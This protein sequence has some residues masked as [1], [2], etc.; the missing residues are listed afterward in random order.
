MLFYSIASA[1]LPSFSSSTSL[2]SKNSWSVLCTLDPRLKS[3]RFRFPVWAGG[4]RDDGVTGQAGH[5]AMVF[6]DCQ[7]GDNGS[8]RRGIRGSC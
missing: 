5:E 1:L 3:R 8:E 7:G 6:E 2:P 4:K